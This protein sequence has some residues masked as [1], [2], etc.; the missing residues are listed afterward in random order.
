MEEWRYKPAADLGL[1]SRARL[2]S[3]RRESGL[4][5]TLSHLLWQA[6]VKIYLRVYHRLSIRGTEHFPREAP[7]I[8]VANHSSH[9]DA[10]ALAEGLPWRFRHVAFP[11]AAGDV[12]FETGAASFFAAMMLNALPMWRKR[13]GLHDLQELRKRLVDQPAVYILFPEGTR[14]RD[15]TMGSFK[16][17]IGMLVASS[18][19]PVVPC[20]LEG[21]H[22]AFPPRAT[23]PRPYPLTLRIGAPLHFSGTPNERAGWG[24]VAGQLEEAVRALGAGDFGI[25][26]FRDSGN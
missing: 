14:S 17:G 22:R 2:R 26:G 23:C 4:L 20:Y 13:C 8:M 9:L 21:A 11:I 12:F 7:F 3:L 10:L 25:P 5:S 24:A 15:G 18:N 16:L 6:L 19:V 1:D